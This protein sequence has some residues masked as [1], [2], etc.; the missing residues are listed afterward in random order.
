MSPYQTRRHEYAVFY[1]RVGPATRWQSWPIACWRR[2]TNQRDS[3]R[4]ARKVR[5]AV[6]AK[7]DSG[8]MAWDAPT[9]YV[10]SDPLVSFSEAPR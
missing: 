8:A 1:D 10:C 6:R 7:I 5:G 4:Y 9:F 2:F 3:I